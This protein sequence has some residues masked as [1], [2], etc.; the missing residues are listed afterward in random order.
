MAG[1]PEKDDDLDE[2]DTKIKLNETLQKVMKKGVSASIFTQEEIDLL[3]SNNID[4]EILS[5]I[6]TTGT[7][8]PLNIKEITNREEEDIMEKLDFLNQI[9]LIKIDTRKKRS[10]INFI[11]CST[12]LEPTPEQRTYFRVQGVE[13]GL[14]KSLPDDMVDFSDEKR[15][16]WL[17]E[18]LIP[19]YPACLM[20]IFK[21][22]KATNLDDLREV[23]NHLVHLRH[24]FWR[25]LE[26]V[27]DN[28]DGVRK[29]RRGYSSIY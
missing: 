5:V 24:V 11:C 15:K 18:D 9:G 25:M 20:L 8:N 13:S 26:K 1:A 29:I 6:S 7:L 4:W 21:K 19:L 17:K 28:M 23:Y 10:E 3:E 14:K 22:E 16:K 2:E 27:A 12:Q